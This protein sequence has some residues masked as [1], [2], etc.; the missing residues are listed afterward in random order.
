[1]RDV[2]LN[3]LLQLIHYSPSKNFEEATVRN[4]EFISSSKTINLYIVIKKVVPITEILEFNDNLKQGMIKIGAC[5]NINITYEYENKVINAELLKEYYEYTLNILKNRKVIFLSLDKF[6]VEFKDNEA[7][8]YVG[9][10]SDVELIEPLFRFVQKSIEALGITFTNFTVKINESI[11]SID[12]TI[13]ESAIDDLNMAITNSRNSGSHKDSKEQVKIYKPEKRKSHINGNPNSISEIPSTEEKLVEYKQLKGSTYFLIEGIVKTS[14]LTITKTGYKIFDATVVD[15]TGAIQIK[16]FITEGKGESQ[17]FYEHKVSKD[18]KV[19][20]YGLAS[21]D[22]FARDVVIKIFE[23]ISYGEYKVSEEHT[24]NSRI[25]R[26]ELHAHSKMTFLDSVLPI[27]KYA[28]RAKEYGH[29]AIA[30]TDKNTVQGLGELSKI[31]KDLGIKPIY[32]IEANYINEKYLYPA[33]SDHDIPLAD[34]TFVVYDLETT[35]INTTYNEI[36]EIGARKVKHGA[37]IGEFTS[38]VNPK[39]LIPS[40]VCKLTNISNDDVRNAPFIEEVLP[41][42]LAF[43]DGC[44]LVGHNVTFDNGQLYHNLKEQGLYKGLIP[45]IDTMQLA[46]AK[47][48]SILKKYGLEDLVKAFNITLDGHHRAE[49]DAVA[50]TEIF[51]KMYNDLINDGIDNY[52]KI[53][54]LVNIDEMYKLIHPYHITMLAKNRTGLVNLNRLV[55]DAHCNHLAK[56]PRFMRNVIEK[57]R[58]GLLIGS[59]CIHGEVFEMALNKDYE[60]LLDVIDFYDYIEVQPLTCYSSLIELKRDEM[61]YEKLQNVVNRII[62]AAKQKNKLV[63]ATGDVHELDVEDRIYRNI[64]YDKPL[65]GGGIHELNGVDNL[66]DTHYRN[67]E[68]M[69]SEFSYLNHDLAYEIVVT[70][71]NKINDMIESYN[72]FPDKLF[73]PGDDFMAEFGIP[74]A[75]EDL[76]KITYEVA[77]NRYGRNGLPQI[78]VDRLNKELGSIKT[79]SYGSIY[80]IA[81]LLVKHSREAGYVVGSRGSVGSSLVATFMRITEVNSLPPHYVCPKCHFTAFKYTKEQIE[82]Y[83]PTKEELDLQ[84]ELWKYDSGL[85]LPPKECPYCHE[86]MAGDGCNIPF[87]TFLGFKGD[88]VPDIDLNF[89]GEYQAKA[90]AFCREIFGVENTFRGGTIGTIAKRTA[91]N[92]IKDYYIKRGK[93]LRN[94]EIEGMTENIMGIKRQ[95]GQHPGG[96]V[97]VP[98]GIDIN[99]VTPVQYP[100]DDITSDWKTTHVDYHKFE[101]NLLKLDILGHDDPTMMRYLM[102]F[103]DENPNEF[104]FTRVED[105]PL[106]DENV[107]KMFSGIDVLGVTYDQVLSKI[108]STG[109]PEFG[110]SLTKNMLCEIRPTTISDLIRISGLSHGTDVWSGNARDYFLGKRPGYDPIP[111]SELICCRDDIMVKLIE[112]GL[113]PQNAFKI[114][115]AVRKGRGLS[116]ENEALMVKFGVPEWYIDCCKKIKYLFPKAHAT[117]YVIMALRIAWFKFYKPLYFYSGFFSKRSDFFEVDTLQGGFDSIKARVEEFEKKYGNYDDTGDDD[118]SSQSVKED[119]GGG[120]AVKEKRLLNVLRVALEMVSRGYSFIGVDIN[121]SDAVNFKIEGNSLIIPFVAI[122]SFGENTA[123]QLVQRRGNEPFTSRRDAE[124]RGHISNSLFEKLYQ[125]GAFDGL[126]LDDEIGIFKFLNDDDKN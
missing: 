13:K 72:L 44:I 3:K 17:E 5:L 35:G 70:N 64:I 110:T 15:K 90:H 59:S 68:E 99:E 108:A 22:T 67:T 60:D 16:T 123:K 119:S 43:I 54:S 81:Y 80:Y 24:D 69:L 57:H 55:T 56:T 94:C 71:T 4:V 48:S 88:K 25:K 1:M 14:K 74:S 8:I 76:E 113:P 49:N 7:I 65:I 63:V 52:N 100:A 66:P 124:R 89:S 62:K 122:D 2:A 32:G 30:L 86:I 27:D 28:K 96:I 75:L 106:N 50:T 36:I 114:M 12:E 47:Y 126:P 109:L 77:N 91:E 33:L 42:F 46:R 121:K 61:T 125:F 84:D 85:D 78:I 21:Y 116:P 104:P 40:D 83:N 53:N 18:N 9:G 39:R 92:Y 11:V 45:T 118:D 87:E 38:L 112:T 73:A 107:L 97:V 120:S 115:E 19:R 10:D 111:I 51:I 103:V 58:E 6:Q 93:V 37:V 31:T 117:A 23:I 101:A 105:I 26:V 34:A 98:K 82:K 20:V 79:Y 41:K 95:T 29:S 102:N